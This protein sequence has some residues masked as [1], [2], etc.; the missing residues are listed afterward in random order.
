MKKKL[1][2]LNWLRTFEAAARH[3]NLTQASVELNLTQAA[4]SQHIKGLEFQL[5]SALFRRLPRGLELTD[6]GKAFLPVV[7]E[8]IKRLTTA[9]N[10]IFGQG[11]TRLLTVRTN[12]VFFTTWIAPRFTGFCEQ[13]PDVGVRCTLSV[14]K[15]AWAIGS[16][17]LVC[18]TSGFPMKFS[19]IP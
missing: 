18:L 16:I 1:P 9:T 19:L 11:K 4:T 15:K 10:E 6:A 12:L 14:T 5:S 3:L 2:P 8:C 17:R 13:Y 7:H